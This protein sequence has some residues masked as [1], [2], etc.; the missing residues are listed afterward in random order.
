MEVSE[1]EEGTQHQVHGTE[2]NTQ[3]CLGAWNQ[4]P[5]LRSHD[6]RCMEDMQG[7]KNIWVTRSYRLDATIFH[8]AETGR[9][10][11]KEKDKSGGGSSWYPVVK[12]TASEWQDHLILW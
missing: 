12:R 11:T 2:F 1:A 3:Y 10:K 6:T 7:K 8:T 5:A 4:N 9:E